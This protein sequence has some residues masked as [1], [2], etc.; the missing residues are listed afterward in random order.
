MKGRSSI[1]LGVFGYQNHNFV[2]DVPDMLQIKKVICNG[3]ISHK[4]TGYTVLSYVN[5][6]IYI[7]YR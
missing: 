6:F 3:K 5:I 7:C 4:R 1:P 2:T